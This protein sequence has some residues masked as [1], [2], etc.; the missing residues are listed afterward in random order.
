MEL[1]EV[2]S[3]QVVSSG[4]LKAIRDKIVLEKQLLVRAV[5]SL[6]PNFNTNGANIQELYN[7]LVSEYPEVVQGLRAVRAG[8]EIRVRDE[9]AKGLARRRDPNKVLN[10]DIDWK[11]VPADDEGF[12]E[13]RRRMVSLLNYDLQTARLAKIKSINERRLVS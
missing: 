7:N 13:F 3:A 2:V 4:Q 5:L 12:E 9:E 10:F 8:A 1:S 6:F 11:N